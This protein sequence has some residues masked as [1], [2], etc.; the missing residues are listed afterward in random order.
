MSPTWVYLTEMGLLSIVFSIPFIVRTLEYTSAFIGKQNLT[1][2]EK[3]M[4]IV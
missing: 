1:L 4:F 3:R 2:I